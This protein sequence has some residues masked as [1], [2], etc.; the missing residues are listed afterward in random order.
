MSKKEPTA[1]ISQFAK[2]IPKAELHLHLEG[3]IPLRT[4]FDFIQRAGTE[5]SIKTIN[6]LVERFHYTDFSHFLDLWVWKNTFIQKEEDFEELAYQ[7]LKGLA[8]EN[9]KYV[10]A[11][12]SPAEY[13]QQGLSVQ[14]IT[15][16]LIKGK[17]RACKEFGIKSE[18]IVDLV[19]DYGPE[20]GMQVM[21]DLTPYLGNGLIG[22]GLGGNERVFPAE[23][24]AT[25]YQEAKKR[26]FRLT[27][28]AGECEGAESMWAA[29]N[30]LKP[31]RIGHGI[32]A[33]E[34]PKLVSF[35]QECQIPLEMC[36]TSNVKTG[37]CESVKEHPIKEYFQEGLLITLNSD[38]PSMFNSSISNEYIILNQELGFSLSELK[39]I[40]MNGVD[41]SFMNERDKEFVK[42]KFEHD[43]T[44]LLDRYH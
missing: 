14:G 34:D 1:S 38:D 15:E 33:N 16:S 41:A 20:I 19:R 32:R 7:V 35:L 10:E 8:G 43:W 17:E 44:K 26:G 5:P 4:L 40:S 31:E 28:H 25:V 13:W 30:T 11:F 22:I 23:A 6:D 21:K 37:V 39:Q 3:A 27:V 12:Y 18:L 36:V 24:Y 29:I 2:E 9:V 42:S